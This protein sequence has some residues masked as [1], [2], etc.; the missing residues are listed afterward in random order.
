MWPIFGVFIVLYSSLI[1]FNLNFNLFPKIE[2]NN[3]LLR[4][5]QFEKFQL[6]PVG[7][8]L[9]I[10]YFEINMNKLHQIKIIEQE[11]TLAHYI[12]VV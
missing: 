3:F 6:I 8:E 11:T 5:A 2:R 9:I 1:N 7:Y 4:N 10:L 12:T